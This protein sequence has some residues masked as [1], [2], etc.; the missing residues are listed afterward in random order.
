M[1]VANTI[2]FQKQ[3]DDI[4]ADNNALSPFL[5]RYITI[6]LPYERGADGTVIVLVC[7]TTGTRQSSNYSYHGHIRVEGHPV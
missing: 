4:A 1:K 5:P 6:S 3:S 2:R 7:L